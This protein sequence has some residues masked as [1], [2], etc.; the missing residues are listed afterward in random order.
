[1]TWRDQTRR[2]KRGRLKTR[3]RRRARAK[4]GALFHCGSCGKRHGN[5]LGHRCTG[6]GRFK[7]L[8]GR[9]ARARAASAERQKSAEARERETAARR[10][11]RRKEDEA[12]RGRRLREREAS[13]AKTARAKAR[14]PSRRSS[15]PTH[16]YR[17]CRDA[18]CQRIPCEAYREGYDDGFGSATE[19]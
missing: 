13:K 17:R 11:R 15:R 19:E 6:G 10:E 4:R 18:D 9:E 7:Q 1:M 5:P 16:D 8:A 12:R 2:P 14:P 3:I